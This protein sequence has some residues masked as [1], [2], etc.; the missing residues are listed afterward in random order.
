[1]PRRR[2]F[3]G[4]GL[5]RI[6]R[7][8][9]SKPCQAAT[10]RSGSRSAIFGR[11]P[12]ETA[13]ATAD[14]QHPTEGDV[15]RCRGRSVLFQQLTQ[16]LRLQRVPER[17]IFAGFSRFGEIDPPTLGPDPQVTDLLSAFLRY[18]VGLFTGVCLGRIRVCAG[19]G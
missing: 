2:L 12:I 16:L 19:S 3:G 18:A 13:T 5:V 7:L 11:G 17:E 8:R 9:W 14:Q 1:M 4:T 6:D 15:P 10:R